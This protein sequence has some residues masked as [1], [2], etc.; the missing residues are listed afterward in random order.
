V[1]ALVVIGLAL[2]LGMSCGQVYRPVVIPIQNNP[3]NPANF[4][5]VFGISTNVSTSPGTALQIDVSGDSNIG[6]ANLGINPTHA[7]GLPNNARIFVASAGSVSG[8][9]ADIISAFVPAQPSITATG[10]TNAVTYSMPNVGPNQTSAITAI[11]ESGNV[12]TVTLQSAIGQATVGGPIVISGV[13][14]GGYDGNFTISSVSGTTIQYSNCV[15]TSTGLQCTTGLAPTTGGTALVPLPTFCSYQPDYLTTTQSTAFYVA[16]Y[17]QENGPTCNLASTDSVAVLNTTSNTLANIRYLPAGSH[18]V[19]MVETPNALNL[20]V[21]NQGNGTSAST[22]MNLSP[23]DLS[24][25]ATIPVGINPAWIAA[26]LNG[27]RVYVVTAG[28]NQLFTIDTS[29]NT[30][31]STQNLGPNP[32]ANYALYDKNLDRLYVP[33]PNNGTV[34][35]FSTTTDP[36]TLL[37]GA[38]L[39]IPPA[40]PCAAAG[41]GCGPVVP[42]AI[43]ALPDGSRFYVASYQTQSPCSDPNVASG[44]CVI[45]YVTVYDAPSLTVKQLATSIF[46]PEISLFTAPPFGTGQYAVPELAFC[47]TPAIYKPGTTRFRMFATAA[48]DSSHVYVSICDAGAIADISTA[49]NTLS[50]GTNAPDTLVIDLLAPFSAAAPVGNSNPPPQSP[51]FLLPGQ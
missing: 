28:D 21:V 30:V 43:A 42:S 6:V 5:A 38:P 20:Y 40:L 1:G 49:T 29:T 41:T 14:I 3:P 24:T 25:I 8:P 16:N 11:S 44:A 32:G 51:I 47:Q 2:I 31:L 45:P 17:G 23:V 34:Y 37:T 48:P 7:A 46:A 19:A 26:R 12:V 18:P 15:N 39:T 9:E 27:Q 36:P 33:S 13:S 4:H 10:I 22:V 50:Q 35:V